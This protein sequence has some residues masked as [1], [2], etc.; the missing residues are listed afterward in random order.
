M[1]GDWT[2][3]IAVLVLGLG[4]G[5]LLVWRLGKGG[6]GRAAGRELELADLERRQQEL[7]ARLRAARA[8]GDEEEV[9]ELEHQAAV[10]LRD[11][12]TLGA[13]VPVT[14]RRTSAAG[15]PGGASTPA[16][17]PVPAAA[18]RQG[19]MGFVAGVAVAAL[20]G[21][22]VFW[23]Q[24]DAG[25]RPG[26]AQQPMGGEEHPQGAELS[27]EDRARIEQLRLAVEADPSDLSARK[28]YALG[29]LGTGQFFGAFQQAEEILA[30]VP[31]DPDGLY[32]AAMVRLQMGQDEASVEL[33]D[34]VLA[35]FPQHVL[36]LTGKGVAMY[37]AGNELGARV[38]WQQAKEAS[39]GDNPQVEHLLD[40]L[41]TRV[42]EEG[43]GPAERATGDVPTAPAAPP[44]VA[45]DAG[46]PDPSGPAY[47]IVIRLA[48]G[49]RPPPQAFLF[50][51]LRGDAPGPPAAVK[52]LT[53]SSFPLEITL[54]A[55]D[56]MLGRPL[57]ASG[58]VGARLRQRLH[59]SRRG[60]RGRGSGRRRLG[61][62]A[63]AATLSSRG[64]W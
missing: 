48:E 50:V 32:V 24:R 36:A 56:S 40:M 14:D 34:A 47:R 28:R 53:G 22:L 27:A 18:P 44:P 33:F 51:T 55:A 6:G 39:G 2:L 43:E 23:A 8:E 15:R 41:D 20:V 30:A 19:V 59:P 42:E 26:A 63:R 64:R 12:E 7:Y 57:P 17:A 60:P 45:A 13:T 3:V 54:S 9:Q 31:G 52:R 10:N 61:H 4:A 16:A 1:N 29:L 62:R 37:R 21:V 5:G 11:L 49:A 46:S 35:Q 25:P 38:L 58:I